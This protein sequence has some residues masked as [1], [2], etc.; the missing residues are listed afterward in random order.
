MPPV[1]KIMARFAPSQREL[2]LHY[3]EH[4]A[5][6]GIQRVALLAILREAAGKAGCA[7]HWQTRIER[8]ESAAG[9]LMDA[10]GHRYGAFDLIIATDGAQ[11]LMRWHG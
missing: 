6:C 8:A 3:P 4:N 11:S 10:Q 2:D 1:E 5:A 7:V 9:F